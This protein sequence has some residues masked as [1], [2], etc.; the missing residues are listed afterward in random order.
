MKIGKLVQIKVPKVFSRVKI[1]NTNVKPSIPTSEKDKS[2]YEEKSPIYGVKWVNDT[3]T[4]ME[5]TD[6]AVGLS[7]NINRDTGEVKSDFDNL[8]PWNGEI[9]Q[10]FLGN[11]FK[12]F[13]AGYF[14][15]GLDE[16]G[17]INSIAVSEK[18][19]GKG[20]WYHYDEFWYGCYGASEEGSGLASKS[21]VGRLFNNTCEQFR[22]KAKKTGDG[23]QQLD[24]K[25]KMITVFLWWIEFATKKSDSIMSG[26]ISGS[27]TLGITSRLNTGGT[28]SITTP[29]GFETAYAQ[30][31]WHGIEDFIGNL[32]EFIDGISGSTNDKVWVCDNPLKFSDTIGADGYEQVS[33]TTPS[34]TDAINAFGWDKSH[35]F[36]CYF[37]KAGEEGFSDYGYQPNSSYPCVYS[38]AAYNNSS[39]SRGLVFFDGSSISNLT[40]NIGGRLLYVPKY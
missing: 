37:T 25:H 8:F 22:T 17:Y 9:V 19:S 24:L 2:D 28:D 10:D 1:I 33:F 27:G 15:V 14:R 12:K 31:E 30:M 21:N 35:P 26:R 20:D 40:N 16:E 11:K 39:A 7:F 38:G 6:D 18:P 32:Y 29:S 36:M 13:Q 4:T 23:Y 5:R 3:S 34:K